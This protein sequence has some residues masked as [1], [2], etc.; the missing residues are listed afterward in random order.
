[1]K[2]KPAR[3][4]ALALQD[5]EATIRYSPSIP[6]FFFGITNVSVRYLAEAEVAA[7]SL[8]VCSGQ[9]TCHRSV[10]STERPPS[11]TGHADS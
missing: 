6:A 2:G 8:G 10:V 3:Q 4:R 9:H 7:L 5:V 11:V 1:M